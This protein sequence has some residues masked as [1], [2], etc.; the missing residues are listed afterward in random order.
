MRVKS[1]ATKFFLFTL[2]FSFIPVASFS[3]EKVNP[4]SPCNSQNQTTQYLGKTYTCLKTGK[5]L[6]WS[7]G[8]SNTTQASKLANLKY[9]EPTQPS[10]NIELC[11]TVEKSSTRQGI[12]NDLATGFPSV[13][14][15]AIKNG[16]VK[17]ALVPLEFTDIR[18]DANFKARVKDQMALLTEWYASVS[19]GKFKIEW[20]VADKWITLPGE[21]SDYKIPFSDGTDRSPAVA[22]F[23]NKA[24]SESDK[25]FDFT[26]VQ[27]V[28]FILPLNQNVVSETLQGFPW[29]NSLKNYSTQEGKITS[30]SI[31]GAFM[32]QYNRKYWSY[33]AH[34]FGHAMGMPHIGSSREA[35]PY[36]GLDLMGGNDG[37]ARE[38]S[39]WLRF[40]AGWLD[41]NKVY[42][43]ELAKLSKTDLT[44]VPLSGTDNGLKMVV[45]PVSDS[46]TLIIESRRETKFSCTMPNK[47]NGVLA[48]LYDATLG[49]GENFLI[50]I[51]PKGR[52]AVGSSDCQVSRFP[53]PLLYKGQKISVEGVTIEVLNSQNLD[54]IR[55]SR[56]S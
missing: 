38:L 41:D 17:W 55:I 29:E 50:P 52:K 26:N 32:N 6:I 25:Y 3:A 19:E 43:Q 46:K 56:A 11:K 9:T 42:C 15:L 21:S 14:S 36:M 10:S 54:K 2:I 7:K 1:S 5:N 27:T 33:W 13:S 44:L 28:N 39:G 23:W 30:F 4:G 35:N 16:T 45:I 24:I 40:V 20:V 22:E 47:R 34:E 51:T 8:V 53:D 31:P 12:A 49:H 37:Y 48:Y 18:G